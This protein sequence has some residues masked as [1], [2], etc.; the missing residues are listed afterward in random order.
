MNMSDEEVRYAIRRTVL[1]GRASERA[2]GSG[3]CMRTS[4]CGQDTPSHHLCCRA[5]GYIRTHRHTSVVWTLHDRL[6]E[7]SS[8][9]VEREVVMGSSRMD[10]VA[11]VGD[12]MWNIDI[13]IV[14]IPDI[15]SN[16]PSSTL[17]QPSEATIEAEV[18]KGLQEGEH[19]ILHPAREITD[20]LLVQAVNPMPGA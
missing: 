20:G 15:Y 3:R 8:G 10:L 5:N 9:P 16:D 13:G 2:G 17:E 6:K 1:C 12:E 18:L 19:V 7:V 14:A 11:N 4:M